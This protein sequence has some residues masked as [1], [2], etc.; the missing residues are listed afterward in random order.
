MKFDNYANLHKGQRCFILGNAPSLK[1]ED[2]S[3]LKDENVFIVNRGYLASELGLQNYMYYVCADEKVYNSAPAE[4]QKYVNVP[5]FY[6]HKI[7][8][9]K[10]YGKEDYIP[11][12]KSHSHTGLLNGQFPTSFKE[13]WGNTRTVAFDASLIAYFMGFSEIYLLGV[14]LYHPTKENSHFY[15]VEERENKSFG[16]YRK[17]TEEI[18]TIITNFAEFFQKNN[19]IFKNLSRD[20][21]FKEHM[22]TDLLDNIM[23]K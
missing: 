17:R 1:K 4:I 12:K 9:S 10:Q 6:H 8:K 3:L 7:Y 15:E 18:S 19:I 21:A 14:D 23:R 2:L 22:Q 16:A 11:I 20:F 13:G 5:R